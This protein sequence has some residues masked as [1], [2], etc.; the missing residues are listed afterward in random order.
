MQEKISA[1]EQNKTWTVATIVNN[2]RI[3]CCKWFTKWNTKL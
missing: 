3:I 2:K 1:L